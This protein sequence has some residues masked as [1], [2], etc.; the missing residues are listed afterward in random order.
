MTKTSVP[1]S[2]EGEIAKIKI[3][4]PLVELITQDVYKKQVLKA[5]NMGSDT[6]TLNFAYDK[7]KLLFGP[8][9]EG[10]YQEG[11]VPPFYV[12]LNLHDKIFQNHA[13]LKCFTQS[14]AK[15]INENPRL[16]NY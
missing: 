15:S 3:T 10:K 8:E 16:R 14:Y 4:I 7:P 9:V 5:L 12:N 13:R 1:F 11:T 6:D 2:L